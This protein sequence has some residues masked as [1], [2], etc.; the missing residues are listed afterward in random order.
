MPHNTQAQQSQP[1]AT[2]SSSAGSGTSLG[3]NVATGIAQPVLQRRFGV[4]VQG[5]PISFSGQVIATGINLF[6]K[7]L[8]LIVEQSV[9]N[10]EHVTIQN[11]IDNPGYDIQIEL[12]DDHMNV[13]E[14]LMF[15]NCK[16]TN[17]QATLDYTSNQPM[18]HDVEF[19]Y[20]TFQASSGAANAVKTAYNSAMSII[21][22]RK[23]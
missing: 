12:Y 3:S 10:M 6:K 19:E 8:L 14:T 22:G 17:H 15:K 20:D 11:L 21:G 23:P 7:Q 4:T 2:S 9:S 13:L 16:V 5:T 1:K 18:W